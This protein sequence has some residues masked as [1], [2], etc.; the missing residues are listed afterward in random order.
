MS[1]LN[2]SLSINRNFNYQELITP[3]EIQSDI[4]KLKKTIEKKH[5][6]IN[7]EG[8]KTLLFNQLDKIK[9][10]DQTITLDSFENRISS[11]VNNI[12]DGHSRV[13]HQDSLDKMNRNSFVAIQISDS[14]TYLR[15]GNFI[16]TNELKN[17]LALFRN[18]YAKN[19]SPNIIIDIRDNFGGEIQ[20]VNRVLSHFI[21]SKTKL[22][23][24]VEVKSTSILSALSNKLLSAKQNIKHFKYTS[25]KRINGEPKLYL[26]INEHIAS[27]SMLLS[28]HLQKNGATVIGQRPRG[29]FNTFGNSYGYRLPHSKILYTLATIR[30]Y[31]KKEKTMRMED[32]ITPNYIPNSNWEIRD[33]TSFIEVNSKE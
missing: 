5:F 11:I 29:L 7:W 26:W 8:K 13:I 28:Y 33:I 15:I 23:E 21:P 4:N 2:C 12:D 6:D 3:A 19:S 9:Q 31:L 25:K 32:M 20:N 1:I 27:G 14:I 10:I 30:V 16:K 24:K 22:Y 18:I 17:T